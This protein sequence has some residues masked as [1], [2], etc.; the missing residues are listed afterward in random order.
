MAALAAELGIATFKTFNEGDNIYYRNGSGR[1]FSSSTPVL[2]PVP[3]DVPGAVEA[4]AALALLN[5]MAAGVPRE[6]PWTA[7]AAREYDGQTFETWKLDHTVSDGGRFL[8]DVGTEA[9]FAC[10]PRDV[11]LLFVLFYIAAAGN[12]TTPGT[13][14]RLI[15]TGGGAQESRFVGGSQQISS[16]LA[17]RLGTRV[18]TSAPVRRIV[19]SGSG[20]RAEADGLAVDA[21]QAIVAMAPALTA[22]IDF[23]P[24]LPSQR[25]Q[26][27]QRYPMGSVFKCQAIY[28]KPFWRD[29][30]LTGQVVGDAEPVRI[31]FD[32]SP[33]EGTP[34]VMLGFIEGEAARVWSEKPPGERRAAVL[35]NFASYF[36]ERARTPIDYVEM[37]WQDEIWSRGCYEG[38]TAPGV[39]LNYG[40]AIRT[41]V[42]RVHWAGT[43]TSPIWNGYMEGAVRSGE[44][45]AGEVLPLLSRSTATPPPAAAP[46]A[47]RK[48]RQ[49]RRARRRDPARTPGKEAGPVETKGSGLPF[50]GLE[51]AGLV[52]AALGL[53]ASGA[54]MRRAARNEGADDA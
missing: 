46:E 3:P 33:R 23:E 34:G 30:G 41:P 53:G 44:R 39:L 15:N 2:G 18:H 11:S 1:R 32:N 8:L 17:R 45:A 51:L 48:G 10:E 22:A 49:P 16:A 25:A 35:D 7:A 28:D 43:E 42:G 14:E 54:A 24:A 6:A 20:V 52:A 36:G 38:F 12:E 31:T 26:L 37:S 47:R 4:G 9:V 27:I 19:Q 40:P 29:D 21:Q 50:T 5:D 13:F